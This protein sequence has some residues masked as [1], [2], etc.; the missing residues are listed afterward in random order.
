MVMVFVI[1]RLEHV[2]VF[3][4]GQGMIALLL[5]VLVLHNVQVVERA[6]ALLRHQSV[7]AIQAITV[8]NVNIW[9]PQV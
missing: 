1:D 9:L 6:V 2:L 8:L 5:Y 4:G 3:L 7:F